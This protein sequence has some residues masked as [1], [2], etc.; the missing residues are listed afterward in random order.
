M[1][2]IAS[3]AGSGGTLFAGIIIGAVLA[4]AF[5]RWY[6]LKDGRAKLQAKEDEIKAL[7]NRG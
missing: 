5:A 7:R 6:Y 3:A 1:N 2:E 4:W